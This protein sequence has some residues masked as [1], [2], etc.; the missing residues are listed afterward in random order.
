MKI[1]IQ[2]LTF[3]CIIGILNKER[4]KKQKV[5][6]NISFKYDFLN[7]NNFIDY[8]KIVKKVKKIMKREK[9][10]LLEE[11]ILYLTKYLKQKYCLK[12]LNIQISKPNILKNC[13]VCL[14]N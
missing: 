9:F 12:S 1:N 2:N 4:V 3:S 14:E 5:I 11:A 8:S 7:K 13:V 6:I 10:E